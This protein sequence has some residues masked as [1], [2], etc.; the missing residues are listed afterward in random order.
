MSDKFLHGINF[1]SVKDSKS[2]SISILPYEAY[3]A[4]QSRLGYISES[5]FKRSPI[6]FPFTRF[7]GINSNYKEAYQK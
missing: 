3:I 1:S 7:N 2:N 6:A 4:R 5:G